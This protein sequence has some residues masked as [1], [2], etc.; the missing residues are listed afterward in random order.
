M[1]RITAYVGIGSNL[2]NPQTNVEQA[3]LQLDKLP[4]TRVT[5]RS[6]LFR[7]APIDA[8]GDDF[9]NAVARLETRLSAQE[10]LHELQAIENTYERERPYVNAPRTLEK[11]A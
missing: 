10:L 9:I 4:K 1:A 2:G 3:M 11:D 5:G 7:T 6:C 8:E